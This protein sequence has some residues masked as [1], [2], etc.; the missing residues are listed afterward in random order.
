MLHSAL[1][2]H[3]AELSLRRIMLLLL[4]CSVVMPV[5]LEESSESRNND[6]VTGCVEGERAVWYPR[7]QKLQAVP[8]G[9]AGSGSGGGCWW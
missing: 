8:R 3:L 4:K 2:H 9:G 7:G 6:T 5:K 1:A